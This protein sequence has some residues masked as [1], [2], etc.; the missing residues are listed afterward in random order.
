MASLEDTAISP[1]TVPTQGGGTPDQ[2]KSQLPS[3]DQIFIGVGGVEY[4][5][6]TQIPSTK[7]WPNFHF[8]GEGCTPDQLKSTQS[9]GQV[10]IWGGVG[11]QTN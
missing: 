11:P 5:R 8:W 10:L 3:H 7:Y 2:L 4:S 9:P 1:H 6:S